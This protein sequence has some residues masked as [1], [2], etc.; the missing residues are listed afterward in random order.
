M[1]LAIKNASLNLSKWAGAKE[2]F[3]SKGAYKNFGPMFSDRKI[4]K[5]LLP[6]LTDFTNKE[7]YDLVSQSRYS[8]GNNWVSKSAADA[9]FN[10][11]DVFLTTTDDHDFSFDA[12]SVSNNGDEWSFLSVFMFSTGSRAL[13]NQVFFS[14]ADRFSILFAALCQWDSGAGLL[15]FSP[16]GSNLNTVASSD[17]PADNVPFL[18][19]VDYKRSTGTSHIYINDPVTPKGQRFTHTAPVALQPNY[20]WGIGSKYAIP[21]INFKGKIGAV[22]IRNAVW[23]NTLRN[24]MFTVFRDYYKITG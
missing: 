19:G 22:Y 15:S 16:N 23:G 1:A 12:A 21:D 5:L 2:T 7:G 14:T 4:D 17:V 10:N 11:R 13:P 18:L 6:E 3:D 8:W 20:S 9:A 24:N